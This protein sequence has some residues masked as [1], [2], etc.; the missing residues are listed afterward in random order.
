ML[1]V[2]IKETTTTAGTGAVTLSAVGGFGRVSDLLGIGDVVAYMLESGNGD[3]EW[4]LGVVGAA[5]TMTRP[6]V[7][8]KCVSGVLQDSETPLSLVGTSTLVLTPH[9]QAGLGGALYVGTPDGGAR[10]WCPYIANAATNTTYT[11]TANQAIFYPFQ[12]QSLV[13]AFTALQVQVWVSGGSSCQLAVY[14]STL[15]ANGWRPGRRVAHGSVSTTTSGVKSI[16]ATFRPRPGAVYWLAAVA[17]SALQV[18]G[19][20]AAALQNVFGYLEGEDNTGFH[21]RVDAAVNL[22]TD[23]SA[24]SYSTASSGGV[25]LLFLRY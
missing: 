21:I 17:D 5:N 4:G 12:V 13:K 9:A 10:R 15:T 23:A 11:M 6:R 24:L 2:G 16:T 8:R 3:R 18:K 7:S 14:E 25:A 19:H 20:S 22:P 1:E